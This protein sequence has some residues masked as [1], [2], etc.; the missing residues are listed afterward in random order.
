MVGF[1]PV[2]FFKNDR[3]Q[4]DGVIFSTKTIGIDCFATCQASLKNRKSL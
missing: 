1:K 2:K 4:H 3:K